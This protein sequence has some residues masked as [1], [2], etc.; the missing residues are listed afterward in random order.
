M[1]EY[2]LVY[3]IEAQLRH[4]RGDQMLNPKFFSLNISLQDGKW[5]TDICQKVEVDFLGFQS[6]EVDFPNKLI[7]VVF[8][9]LHILLTFNNT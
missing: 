9:K 6:S 2:D 7:S 4:R 8:F 3:H 5:K 1:S